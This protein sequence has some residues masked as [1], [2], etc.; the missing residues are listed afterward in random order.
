MSAFDGLAA[1]IE[2]VMQQVG[3]TQTLRAITDPGTFV[4]DGASGG[5]V[6]GQVVE[7]VEVM[8]SPI[9]EL[10]EDFGGARPGSTAY[11]RTG[12]VTLAAS[13]LSVVPRRGWTMVIDGTAY[14]VL[15]VEHFKGSEVLAYELTLD[16]GGAV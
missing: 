14:G 5:T 10:R 12:K 9:Y 3:S 13:G 2:S 11:R 16:M 15:L 8:C 1:Q 6:T 4:R 7:D